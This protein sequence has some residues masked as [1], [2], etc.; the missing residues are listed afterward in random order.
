MTCLYIARPRII[1]NKY[2]YFLI[3]IQ[4]MHLVIGKVQTKQNKTKLIYDPTTES[5]H[6]WSP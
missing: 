2:S 5:H 3:F 4:E 6:Y 1:F